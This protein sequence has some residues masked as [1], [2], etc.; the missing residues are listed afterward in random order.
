MRLYHDVDRLWVAEHA[1]ILPLFY[2]R[3]MLVRRPWVEGLWANPLTQAQLDR[4]VVRRS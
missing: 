1:A 4:A 3:R 2:N